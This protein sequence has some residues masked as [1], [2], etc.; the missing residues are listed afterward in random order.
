MLVVRAQPIRA[1]RA[2]A[3]RT[4]GHHGHATCFWTDSVGTCFW[5][6]SVGTS[7]RLFGHD[8]SLP[9]ASS[10]GTGRLPRVDQGIEDLRKGFADPPG[11]ARPMMRWWWFGP[12]V[13]NAELDR[14]LTAMAAGGL[15]GV[16][17][18]FVYPLSQVTSPFL[19]D[20]FLASVS[21]VAGRAQ[22][23]GLRFDLTLGS[24]WPFGGPHITPDLAARRLAW[25]RTSLTDATAT[26]RPEGPAGGELVGA[27]LRDPDVPDGQP[28]PAEIVDGTV[29]VPAGSA[30]REL[31]AAWSCPT[32]QQ[33]K[34]A[35]V[36]AEGLVLDHYS[37]AAAS[38]HIEQVAA[39][40]LASARPER[41]GSVFCDSMEVYGAD[42]TPALPAEFE[43]RRGYPLLPR[44]G[45]LADASGDATL[46]ADVG[47][48]LSE[49]YGRTSLRS[50]ETGRRARA[51]RS[52]SRAMA[53]RRPP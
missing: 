47:R 35:A 10:G 12:D 16:E 29:T 25:T 32:G 37:A 8:G 23:L 21:F 6:D 45:E 2:D 41:V 7:T 5:T 33:V 24:G 38:C 48:T 36:G 46:R 39:P 52:A 15:G 3:T 34:R 40:L 4:S 22:E 18:A 19:S 9:S 27:Y 20:P 43:R 14:E 17:V 44:L 11:S 13:E 30:G 49:L 53:S 28:R 1:G 26:V 31:L 42:W 51:S 50:S